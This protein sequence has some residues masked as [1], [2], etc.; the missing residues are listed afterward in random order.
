MLNGLK[1]R[2]TLLSSTCITVDNNPFI[3]FSKWMALAIKN[4]PNDPNAMCLSTV[5]GDGH[6][7]SRIVL[8]KDYDDN[9]FVF[10]TNSQSQKGQELAE[11]QNV[12]LGFHWKS[13][14]KQIRINGIAKIIPREETTKYFHSRARESQIASYASLQSQPLPDK[15]IYEDKINAVREQFK[16]EEN[17]PCPDHWNGYRVTP[18]KMEFWTQKDYRTHDRFVYTPDHDDIWSKERLY[19]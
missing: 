17:I 6:P 18:S 1:L 8:L 11:N 14:L 15:R 16:N 2:L 5:D 7:S 13:L 9:G 3:L 4:E 10:F 12:A 19:P